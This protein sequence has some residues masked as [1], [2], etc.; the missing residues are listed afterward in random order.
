[1]SRIA[2]T[3]ELTAE[4]YA[5]LQWLEVRGYAADMILHA[6]EVREAVAGAPGGVVLSYT[7][8]AAWAVS[9]AAHTV[10]GEID[11]AFATCAGPE[12][13]R[14]MVDFLDGIV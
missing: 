2:Y 6:T 13:A 1:M 10:G 4:E 11:H 5:A 8:A 3:V 12:L 9:E 7:E 14:K